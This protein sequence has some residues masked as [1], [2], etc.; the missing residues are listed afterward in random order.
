MSTDYEWLR[1]SG[2]VV[3]G[4]EHDIM[5]DVINLRNLPQSSGPKAQAHFQFQSQSQLSHASRLDSVGTQNQGFT[6]SPCDY[7]AL[8]SF[9]CKSGKASM[10]YRSVIINGCTATHHWI[11]GRNAQ[12]HSISLN[13][14]TAAILP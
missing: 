14:V 7:S 1:L 11:V 13:L 6:P 12:N 4:Q 5:N 2:C 8:V 3:T 10:L 9:H